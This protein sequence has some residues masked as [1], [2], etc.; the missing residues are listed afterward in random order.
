MDPVGGMLS[1]MVM[2]WVSL[3]SLRQKS[4]VLQVRVIVVAPSHAPSVVSSEKVKFASS[5]S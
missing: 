2:T 4:V 1:R 5:K 3:F